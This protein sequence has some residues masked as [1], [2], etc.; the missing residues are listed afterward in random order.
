MF[1]KVVNGADVGMIQRG[2]RARF[3]QKALRGEPVRRQLVWKE[4]DGYKAGKL[5]VLGAIDHAHP[6]TIEF[7]ENAVVREELPK[8][9]IRGRHHYNIR[10][11][12]ESK[13]IQMLLILNDLRRM[14]R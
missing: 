3:A 1:T 12:A 5:Q 9:N 4:F 6:A 13:A 11:A 14:R 10:C 2:R 7:L 8:K